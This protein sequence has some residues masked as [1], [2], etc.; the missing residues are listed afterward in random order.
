MVRFNK[1]GKGFTLIEMI[2]T[3][4]ILAILAAV[5]IPLAQN[6][7]K[8]DKEIELRRTLRMKKRS[9]LKIK[10]RGILQI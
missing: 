7:V 6:A 5:A 4:S 1:I 2:I 3:L 10:Q 9:R 8:R